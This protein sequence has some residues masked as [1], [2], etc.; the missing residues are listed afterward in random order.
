M[1]PLMAQN[2]I[3]GELAEALGV[4][5]KQCTGM[6]LRI[7]PGRLVTLVASYVVTE[8]QFRTATQIIKNYKLKAV[9]E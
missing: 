5:N 1:K 4:S 6:N 3:I 9:S 7:R 8:D 2:P